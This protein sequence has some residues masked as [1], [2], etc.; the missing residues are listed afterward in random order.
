MILTAD[1]ASRFK[2][3]LPDNLLVDRIARREEDPP[4]AH[5]H[6]DDAAVGR[7][8]DACLEVLHQPE[9]LAESHKLLAVA[10]PDLQVARAAAHTARR[11]LLSL[12]DAAHDGRLAQ[13]HLEARIVLFAE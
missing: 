13:P 7:A 1:I 11:T 2:R 4:P 8:R 9:R 5:P 6:K 3:L 10:V 12:L